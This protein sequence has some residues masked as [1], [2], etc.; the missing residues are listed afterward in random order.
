[1]RAMRSKRNVSKL[2]SL[3][4]ATM[5]IHD[6]PSTLSSLSGTYHT[7]AISLPGLQRDLI[8]PPEALWVACAL[9]L[10]TWVESS[11]T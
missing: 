10:D 9:L 8:Q 7:L 4:E 5:P 2:L 1:M 3:K 11:S 6:A